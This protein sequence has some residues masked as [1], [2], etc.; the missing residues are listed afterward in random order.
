MQLLGDLGLDSLGLVD[1]AVALE[2]KTGKSIGDDALRLELSVDQVRSL[3]AR[4]LS[5]EEGSPAGDA[6]SAETTSLHQPLWPY[7][8]GRALRVLGL[9]IELV[10]RCSVTRTVVV[11]GEHLTD[12]SGRVILAGTHHSRADVSLVQWGL[13]HSPARRLTHRLVIAAAAT[14]FAR[15]LVGWYGVLA[16]GLY[17]LRQYGARDASLRRLMQLA[18]AGN[19]VLIFPQGTYAAPKQEV[20]DDPAVRFRPGVAHLALALEA[21]VVP[22]G[23]AGTQQ[24]MPPSLAEY[25]GRFVAAGR[26]LTITR[27]PLAIAFGA[28][29]TVATGESPQEFTDRLQVA[30]Y[31]L[32][33]EAER[34]L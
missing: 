22:F 12:L 1:L 13:E 16:F 15:G 26:P 30:S 21:S 23:V 18:E 4:A 34:A 19:A 28:P 8:W 6:G 17:P 33:R 3:V 31:A 10:Y 27:G 25:K 14:T 11:G 7:S 29:L 2:E 20:A 32:T 9:P 5:A 24:L